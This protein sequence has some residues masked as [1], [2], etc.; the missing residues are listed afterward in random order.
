VSRTV[1]LRCIASAAAVPCENVLDCVGY[2][3]GT[4]QRDAAV[5]GFGDVAV[6]AFRCGVD[7]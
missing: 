1:P 5:G 4:R 7:G 2:G 6:F 3:G